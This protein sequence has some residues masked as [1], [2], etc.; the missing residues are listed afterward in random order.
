MSNSDGY[1]VTHP[2]ITK[3]TTI[4]LGIFHSLK[5]YAPQHSQFTCL[6]GRQDKNLSR[7]AFKH[8]YLGLV[9]FGKSV[10]N[11]LGSCRI[12]LN[13]KKIWSQNEY[14]RAFVKAG[15]G[16]GGVS[17]RILERSAGF[18]ADSAATILSNSPWLWAKRHLFATYTLGKG[19]TRH[20]G[21]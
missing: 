10:V 1:I 8:P 5:S 16:G 2:I 14:G 4:H 9:N 12:S 7:F 15:G 3:P 18:P 6:F 13:P 17:A 20:T 11:H 19:R 21:L